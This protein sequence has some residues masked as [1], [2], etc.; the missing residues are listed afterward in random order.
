MKIVLMVVRSSISG[1][2]LLAKQEVKN[3]SLLA[4]GLM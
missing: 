1:C 3:R 4:L 2:Q